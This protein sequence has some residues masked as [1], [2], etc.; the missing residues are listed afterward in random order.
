MIKHKYTFYLL[1]FT[2]FCEAQKTSIG[3]FYGPS[4]GYNSTYE[5]L[6]NPHGL[7]DINFDT[8][9]SFF[10]TIQMMDDNDL[11]YNIEAINGHTFGL[12]ANLFVTRGISIQPELEFQQLS[13]NHTLYQRGENVIFNSFDLAL[14][15]LQD[16]GQYKIANYLW[17]VDYLNFPFILKLYPT[18]K[19]FIK[20]GFKFGFVLKAQE[21][22]VS[23]RFNLEN[24]EYT[25]YEPSFSDVVVYEFFDSDSGIDSHGFDKSEWPFNWNGAVLGGIGFETKSFYFACRYTLGLFPFFKEIE[26]KDD[27]FFENYNSEF[28]SGTYASFEVSDPVL[29]NNFKLQTFH[30]LIGFQL[31]N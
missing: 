12:K 1:F 6:E 20:L 30:F 8:G 7:F 17:Q 4:I 11:S 16:N 21:R 9:E 26:D 28:D 3:F 18:Q 22:R 14:A 31:S 23:A 29:N 2:F 25:E 19:T 15:G 24:G 10:T 27:D 5:G 13:F